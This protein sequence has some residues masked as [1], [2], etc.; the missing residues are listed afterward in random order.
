MRVLFMW[1]IICSIEQA[2]F[3]QGAFSTNFKPDEQGFHFRNAF[4]NTFFD[5]QGV[6]IMVSGCS[7]GMCYAALDYYNR[8][9]KSPKQSSPPPDHSLLY[10]YIYDRQ[11]TSLFE[12]E[13]KWLEEMANPFGWQNNE[14]FNWGLQGTNGGRLQL[15]KTYIDN[16][17]PV[18]IGLFGAADPRSRLHNQVI[19]IGYD[20]GRYQGTLGDYQEDFKI[21]CY[22]PA[23]P[24]NISTLQVNKA[25]HYY[26]WKDHEFDGDH[27]TGYFV[28]TRYT[29][30]TPPPDPETAA[31]LPDCKAHELVVSFMTGENGLSGVDNNCNVMLQFNDGSVQQFRNLNRRMPWIINSSNTVELWLANPLPLQAFKS[32]IIYTRPCDGLN[33]TPCNNWDLNQL[34]IMARGGTRDDTVLNQ[35]GNPLLKR[36]SGKDF[37]GMYYYTNLP[38][39]DTA[40][41]K[42]NAGELNTDESTTNQLLIQIRTGNSELPGGD[43]NLVIT[44]GFRDGSSQVFPNVNAGINWPANTSNLVT[45]NLNNTVNPSDIMYL[46]LQTKNCPE[47]SCNDWYFQGITVK[48]KEKNIE[49]LMY[50]QSGNP[51]YKFS[52]TNSVYN[53]ILKKY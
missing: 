31:I 4:T 51:I 10:D 6:K 24:E 35:I 34:V 47:G 7:G 36:F 5:Q 38:A 39:C 8:K 26:Y 23:Y 28:D 21:Y 52:G 19:A 17:I 32:I 37:S 22:D 12:N 46:K 50:E 29:A 53:I 9:M 13:E 16:G 41:E 25:Q 3:S 27:Y 40:I 44:L 49:K 43:D 33:N 11:M 2:A 20:C 48:A 30:G 15:L 42:T 14:F 1:I 45:L 18:P